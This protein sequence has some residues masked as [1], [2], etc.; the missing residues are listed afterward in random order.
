MGEWFKWTALVCYRVV[1]YLAFQAPKL[2]KTL[3]DLILQKKINKI[4]KSNFL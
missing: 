4:W 3:L 2:F 1:K